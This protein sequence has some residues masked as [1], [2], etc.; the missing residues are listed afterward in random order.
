MSNA[1][2]DH[3]WVGHLSNLRGLQHLDLCIDLSRCELTAAV[4][5]MTGA[6][7]HR[8]CARAN[9]ALYDGVVNAKHAVS[10][11]LF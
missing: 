6:T 11:A 5:V 8:V 4:D 10:Y 9:P 7:T 3:A 1:V 2:H